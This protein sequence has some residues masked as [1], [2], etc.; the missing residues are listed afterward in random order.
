M[1]QRVKLDGPPGD[2]ARLR[3]AVDLG[4]AD[5]LARQELGRE[6]AERADHKRFDELDLAEEVGAALLDLLGKRIAV[7]GRAAL[8][9]VGDEHLVALEPDLLEQAIQELAGATDEGLA[10]P[11]LLR[12]RGLA[13]EHELGVGVARAEHEL[14]ARLGQRTRVVARELA[15]EGD[16]LLAPVG[17]RAGGHDRNGRPPAPRAALSSALAATPLE[18]T[19]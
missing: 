15:V 16:E 14:R 19:Y 6:V 8:D 11:I 18:R 1:E 5:A 2:L 7:A 12:S 17:G 4:D 3:A 9:H 13:D 10:L